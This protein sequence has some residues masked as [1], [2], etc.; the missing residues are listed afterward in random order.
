MSG[1]ALFLVSFVRV[2]QHRPVSLVFDGR[3]SE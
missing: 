3:I 2:A 1:L